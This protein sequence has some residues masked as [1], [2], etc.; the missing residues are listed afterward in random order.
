MTNLTDAEL[1]SLADVIERM[2]GDVP[3]VVEAI[4]DARTASL[5]SALSEAQAEN[6]RLRERTQNV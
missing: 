4:I 2:T 6:E 5:R 3:A 1:R